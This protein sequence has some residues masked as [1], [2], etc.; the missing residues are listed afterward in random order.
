M[1]WT[2]LDWTGL[3]WTDLLYKLHT[4]H[5]T[6]RSIQVVRCVCCYFEEALQP[7]IPTVIL[8]SHATVAKQGGGWGL[9]CTL[10]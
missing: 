7:C 9:E 6:I 1:D 10:C 3:D 5:A 4:K 8:K 2:G